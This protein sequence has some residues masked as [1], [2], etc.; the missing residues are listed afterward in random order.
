MGKCESSR[1]FNEE[2][3]TREKELKC[4]FENKI[5]NIISTNKELSSQSSAY[6]MEVN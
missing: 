3:M 2:E 6:E 4:Y 1:Y 5:N